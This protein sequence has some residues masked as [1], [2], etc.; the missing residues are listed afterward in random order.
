MN[1]ED[2]IIEMFL[3]VHA[4]EPSLKKRR[5]THSIKL[6][7]SSLDYIETLASKAKCRVF[8]RRSKR[9]GE[10]DVNSFMKGLGKDGTKSIPLVNPSFHDVLRYGKRSR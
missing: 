8:G 6:S 4:K 10:P 5:T 3:P 7:G 1:L 9:C 2:Q